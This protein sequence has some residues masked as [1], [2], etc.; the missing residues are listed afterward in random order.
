MISGRGRPAARRGVAHRSPDQ[1]F[2]V[3]RH[4]VEQHAIGHLTGQHRHLRTECPDDERA[5]RPPFSSAAPERTVCSACWLRPLPTPSSNR[6][7]GRPN[8]RKRSPMCAGECWSSGITPTPRVIPTGHGRRR[9]ERRQPLGTWC[10]VHPERGVAKSL[11]FRCNSTNHAVVHRRANPESSSHTRSMPHPGRP[12]PASTYANEDSTSRG[13]HEP[14]S[15][16]ECH[17]AVW[18]S[19]QRAHAPIDRSW[20]RM[21]RSPSVLRW[22]PLGERH[23]VARELVRPSPRARPGGPR[24]SRRSTSASPAAAPASRRRRRTP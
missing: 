11:D 17:S 8:V 19:A 12:S 3:R 16:V 1:C 23:V 7:T 5:G 13:S 21:K 15:V 20:S 22:T 18:S 2:V 14:G 6:P 9:G 24:P 4:P 10:V